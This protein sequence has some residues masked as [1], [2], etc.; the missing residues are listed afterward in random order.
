MTGVRRITTFKKLP[1]KRPNTAATIANAR[2][3]DPSRNH[4]A[5][6]ASTRVW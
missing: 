2:G 6:I 1:I 5:L 3:E 4:N